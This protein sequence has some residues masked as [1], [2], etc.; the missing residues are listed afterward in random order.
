MIW[1]VPKGIDM[2]SFSFYNKYQQNTRRSVQDHYRMTGST[3][4][5]SFTRP[6]L[7]LPSLLFWNHIR[8]GI[9]ALPQREHD[10]HQAPRGVKLN[11]NERRNDRTS[12]PGMEPSRIILREDPLRSYRGTLLAHSQG[13]PQIRHEQF[14]C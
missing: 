9:Q 10:H 2:Q 4:R 5:Y 7:T 3:P 14:G 6:Y 1:K 8:C 13:V 11:R 12:A